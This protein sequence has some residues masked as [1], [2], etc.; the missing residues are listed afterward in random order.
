MT[1]ATL[2][3]A[4][5]MMIGGCGIFGGDDEIKETCHEPQPYQAE[6]LNDPVKAPEGLDQLNEFK[7]MPIPVA[8]TPPRPEGA[9]CITKPPSVLSE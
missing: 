9:G 3:A 7:E 8:E 5:A 2:V 1:R 4:M 6:R